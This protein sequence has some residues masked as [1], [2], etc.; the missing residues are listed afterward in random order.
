M[1]IDYELLL[2]EGVE[3][4]LRKIDGYMAACSEERRAF[5]ACCRECLLGVVEHARAYSRHARNLAAQE[6]DPQRRSELER[7]AEICEKVPAQPAAS[8]YEAVQSVHFVTYCLSMNPLRFFSGQQFQL[9]HPDRYL[10]PFYRRDLGIRK[11]H[12]GIRPAAAGSSGHSDQHAGVQRP[13]QRIYGGRL[14]IAQGRVVAGRADGNGDAGR[15]ATSAWF[16]RPWAF[17]GSPEMPESVSGNRPAISC[18][19]GRSHPG[20]LQ[21]RR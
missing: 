14:G 6:A 20:G 7:I 11:N 16:T 3:G 12:P 18:G 1:A 13:V 5:Y 15:R 4:I 9:G 19:Q 2:R 21:R 17:A 8:F 10:E